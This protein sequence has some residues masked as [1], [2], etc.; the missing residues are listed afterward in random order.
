MKYL[1]ICPCGH[2]LDRH[3]ESG[4]AGDD[5]FGCSCRCDQRAALDA[6]IAQA[7]VDPWQW[8]VAP[9]R[10]GRRASP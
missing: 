1:V 5:R 3:D 7:R 2:T 4:C 6:A 8:Q 10:E 9:L